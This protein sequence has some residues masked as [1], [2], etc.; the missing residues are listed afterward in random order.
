MASGR[1][2][3][4]GLDSDSETH[5]GAAAQRSM[6]NIRMVASGG[7]MLTD[8]RGIPLLLSELLLVGLD[9]WVHILDVYGVARSGTS[10]PS[11]QSLLVEGLIARALLT[12]LM[13]AGDVTDRGFEVWE[14]S[15]ADWVARVVDA[16]SEK[17]LSELM[18][19]HVVWLC[20]TDEGDR[21][22]RE[23]DALKRSGD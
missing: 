10:T 21:L 12:E 7:C 16:H 8:D 18:P 11:T 1:S 22:A 20:N 13:V 19:G 17:E 4:T 15:P 23:Y 9:D 2:F 5:R 14:G 3:L 6:S